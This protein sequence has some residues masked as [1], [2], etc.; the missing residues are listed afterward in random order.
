MRTGASASIQPGDRRQE[1]EAT[2]PIHARLAK[3]TQVCGQAFERATGLHPT[4][5]Q[6]LAYLGSN[7]RASQKDLVAATSIDPGALT[8]LLKQIEAQGWIVRAIDKH[9]NRLTNVT[10][11]ASGRTAFRRVSTRREEFLAR[12]MAGISAEED[13]T[14][15]RLL[16]KIEANLVNPIG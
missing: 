2:I 14:L 3:V 7:P 15:R 9:D 13:R 11:T 12:S 10:L 5:W 8:R 4:R 6:V 16:R 1:L